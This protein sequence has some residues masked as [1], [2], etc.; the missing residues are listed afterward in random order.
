M[1]LPVFEVRKL[2]NRGQAVS[3]KSQSLREAQDGS[4]GL[5]T[6]ETEL[7]PEEAV[8][9]VRVWGV[10]LPSTVKTPKSSSRQGTPTQSG[11]PHTF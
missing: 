11:T 10:V 4:T 9:G 7:F 1:S 6:Q 8:C 2:K 3:S 5:L